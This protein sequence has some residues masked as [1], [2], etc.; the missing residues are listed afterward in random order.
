MINSLIVALSLWFGAAAA[1]PTDVL[2]VAVPT[3]SLSFAHPYMRD[4]GSGTKPVI[5]DALTE[6][7]RDGVL[8]PALAVS[9]NL[10]SPTVW[11]FQ[12]RAGVVFQNGEPFNA[13]T[14]VHNLAYLKTP[15][16][17]GFQVTPDIALVAGA[18]KIDDLTVDILTATPDPLLPQ[19]MGLV[20]MVP[21]RAWDTLGLE[22]FSKSPIGTGAYQLMDWGPGAAAMKLKKFSGSWRAPAAIS[23]IHVNVIADGPTR[24]QALMADQVDVAVNLAP[25]DLSILRQANFAVHQGPGPYVLGIALRTTQPGPSPLKDVRVRQ[26]LQQAIDRDSIARDLLAGTAQVPSQLVPPGVNGY[27]PALKPFAYDPARAKALLADAGYPNGFKVVFSVFGGA[28][29]ADRTIFQKTAQDLAAIGVQ[30]DLRPIAFPDFMRRLGSGDWDG[31]DGFSL[32]F[33]ANEFADA[34]RP[35]EEASCA[36]RQPF[37]CDADISRMISATGTEMNPAKRTQMLQD[38]MARMNDLVPA[39]LVSGYTSIMGLS[40]RVRNFRARTD[41]IVYEEMS[42]VP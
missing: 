4:A 33:R 2:R 28:A 29:P 25:D 22:A 14:V 5:F 21:P 20:W 17:A 8:K 42:L 26:A 12:L 13:A 9:W 40:P 18:K 35:L 32:M 7:S 11:R 31:V 36:F 38:I 23:D 16:A 37:F 19:R 15:A 10:Q 30:V 41:S 34:V 24:L 27:N 1:A 39:L 6:M 3:P